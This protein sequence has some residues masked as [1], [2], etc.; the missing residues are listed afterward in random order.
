[1]I[2]IERIAP[3]T[4]RMERLLDAPVETVWRWLVEPNLRRQWFASG[5]IDP[6]VGGEVELIFDH[7]D[8]S[9]DDVPYAGTQSA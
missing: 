2:D 6:H 1:M 7:D 9:D 5:R 8:L 3:D 4:I